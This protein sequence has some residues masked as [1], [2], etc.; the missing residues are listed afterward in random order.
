M[1]KRPL[2]VESATDCVIMLREI[3]LCR[4]DLRALQ[5]EGIRPISP[6]AKDTNYAEIL[7]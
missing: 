1:C 2:K 4:R 6:T 7:Q 3:S 5:Q